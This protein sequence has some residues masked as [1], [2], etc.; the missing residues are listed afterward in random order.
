MTWNYVP[1]LI[2][3][4]FLLVIIS[5]SMRYRMVPNRR[6]RLFVAMIIMVFIFVFLSITTVMMT[7]HPEAVS[8]PLNVLVHTL[9]FIAYPMVPVL[10]FW[11]LICVIYEHNDR[12]INRIMV[13]SY[14][15]KLIYDVFVLLNPFTKMMWE[16][17]Q[18]TG[19]IAYW[20][21]SLIFVIAIFYM[22]VIMILALLNKT[23][24]SQ[25]LTR[26][27]LAY[28]LI[29]IAFLVIEY[30]FPTLVL[31][32][33]AATL[34]IFILYLYIQNKE[35]MT[36]RLTNLM[37]R[38]AA[39]EQLRLLDKSDKSA[40]LILIS[41]SDFRTINGLYGQAFGD[42]LLQYI[43]EF[44]VSLTR[45]EEVFRYSGDMFLLILREE[46]L[47]VNEILAAIIDRFKSNFTVKDTT[48]SIRAKFVYALYPQHV[49]SSENVVALLEFLIAKAKADPKENLYRSSER[50]L[51]DMTRRSRIIEIIKKAVVNDGFS[52]ALQPIYSITDRTFTKAE[53]LLR[54]YD[55]QLGVI[56]PS[57]FIPLA[58]EAGL[59]IP[60]G[61][62]VTRK[63]VMF[64]KRCNDQGFFLDSI[65]VNYSAN[66]MS[67]FQLVSDVMTLIEKEGIF[68]SQ[69]KI[70]ITE[71]IFISEY[72]QIIANIAS[73][74]KAGIGI[75]LDD[76]G[77]GFS[78]LASVV[79]LPLECVKFD[80][81]LILESTGSLKSMA[82]VKGLVMAFKQSGFPTLAEG[83]ETPE[84][85]A[86][87][88]D[89]GFDLIQGYL[90]SKPL[91]P[92]EF[93]TFMTEQKNE[94]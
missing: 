73:L 13:I 88:E 30:F 52:I 46:Q 5:Y 91:S 51:N 1:E 79:K 75:Y 27:I 43:S 18:S 6:N 50:S 89:L 74:N 72:T 20:G 61:N 71:S 37:N 19:Y 80:R 28:N 35:M 54:L 94:H 65:S 23:V 62:L 40:H 4:S 8:D 66:H 64:I 49:K 70:E 44:L 14:L 38:S 82:M 81:S 76:F 77:T 10:F 9:F 68:P 2:S 11:Y 21:E 57:E 29:F 92:K 26:V 69:L 42:G 31:G 86:M 24:L 39:V 59:I 60:I 48:T 7:S 84:Q 90:K 56:S 17:S 45:R 53:A 33:T 87:V 63:A 34:F 67:K 55:E 3:A 12:L 93:L 47:K 83:V 41:L 16:I 25:Q 15:P 58:E 22:L 78:N 85:E 32:G 36:D